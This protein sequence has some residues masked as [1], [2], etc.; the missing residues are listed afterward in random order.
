M[1]VFSIA[2]ILI[3]LPLIIYLGV[4]LMIDNI[5][6]GIIYVAIFSSFVLSLI[7]INE[8]KVQENNG[9]LK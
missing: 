7:F 8:T 3:L 6:I 4:D 1:K 2:G 9:E 5:F